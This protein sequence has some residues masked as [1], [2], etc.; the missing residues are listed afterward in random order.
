MKT[1]R[2][3]ITG[4][5]ATA[6]AA[7]GGGGEMVARIG[8]G[9]S[10]APIDVG[11]GGV[12]GFGS[13]VINGQHY[14]EAGA[15]FTVDE[16]PDQPTPASVDAVRL[17]MQMQFEHLS[18]RMTKA[19][20]ASEVIGPVASIGASSLVVLGQTVQVNS[21]P[22]APTI[23]DG[24]AA[25]S[26]LA[27]A[28]VEVHGQRNSSA[29]IQATRIQLRSSAGVLRVAGTVT[30]LANGA[31]KIGTL[32][33]RAAAATVVPGGESVANG[34]RV[35]VWTDQ[36]LVNGE[37][38][39]RVVRIGG[40]AIPENA[41][42]TV[43]GLVTDFQ[44]ASSLRIGSIAADASRAQYTG[45]TAADLRNG[46]SVRA[47]G[48]YSGNVLR[49][50]RIEFLSTAPARVE[51]N[52]AV[53][54][55]V[56]ASSSFQVRGTSTKVTAQ[57]TY[58]RG[59]ASNLGN[60]VL[61]KVE[62]PVVNGVIEAATLEFLPPSAGIARVLFGT[63]ANPI[64]AAD[65]T[66]TFRLAPL[67]FDVKT[68]SATSFKKGTVDDL[69]AGAGVKVDGT[70]DGLAFIAE[71]VQFTNNPS[72]PPTFSIDGI[73]SNVQPGSMVVDGKSVFLTPTTAYT[74]SQA[75][76]ENGV[77]VGIEAVKINGQLYANSVAIK[78]QAGGSASVRGIVSGRASD[79]TVAFLVGAQ[80]VS[81]AGN[82]QVTPSNKT[83][84]DIKNGND[85]EVD[86][87]IANGLLT[88]T[89]IKFR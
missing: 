11:V 60:G 48:T 20:V 4:L 77:S 42:L 47:S 49:A 72:D 3:L 57:T 85:L 22:A 61:V 18:N 37:L 55:F 70:Y 30:D 41:A 39:A 45:A 58:V 36:A 74:P 35:A 51:L 67:P 89:R 79:T 12:D 27:G 69:V 31:F 46:R 78:E 65:K 76:L 34:Q 75:K 16:R 15:Q 19:T 6:L 82:P 52:G 2:F 17:G 44:T 64:T 7:C 50:S 21:D 71:E 59:D 24:F 53:A 86:G 83:V 54:S 26:E 33:I 14:E 40:A 66:K 38:V 10:G 73:A 81:V 43:E 84:K 87:T 56:D 25:L 62:G 88:A 68:T 13:I 1:L 8:S 23:F 28:V 63:V 32:T 29:E 9:G 80:R 5:F